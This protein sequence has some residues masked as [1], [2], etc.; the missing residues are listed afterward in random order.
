MDNKESVKKENKMK[1]T[2]FIFIGVLV[3]LPFIH[4]FNG[5]EFTDTAYSLGNYENL[6]NMNMTWTI[7][8]FWANVLGKAFT[9]LPMGNMWIGMKFY[10]TL[11]PVATIIVSYLFLRKYIPKWILFIGEILAVSMFWCPTT[12]LYNYLTYFLF[13]VV[14]VL[15][16]YSLEKQSSLGLLAAGIVLAFSVFTRFP[17]ITEA[18]LIVVVWLDSLI[19]KRKFSKGLANT[20]LC[21]GG[22]LVGVG[23]N[24]GIISL[25]Y[26]FNS[27]PDMIASLFSMTDESTGY[28]PKQM[29]IDILTSYITYTKSYVVLVGIA[30]LVFVLGAIVRKHFMR[31]AFCVAEVILYG[32]FLV[33]AYRS[34]GVF[35]LNYSE[36]ASIYFWMT[37]FLL[38][39]NIFAIWSLLRK[40]TDSVH[41]LLALSTVVIVWITP[42][43]SNNVL[44]PAFNNLCIVA[45][46]TLYM[47][48]NELFRGRNFYELID[49]ESKYSMVATRIIVFLL[50]VS[51]MF[52]SLIFG[53]VFVFRDTGF[54][55]NNHYAIENNEVLKGMH[56]NADNAALISE[57]TV[58]VRENEMENEKAIFYGDLPGLEY[59]LKMPCA[60]SHTWPNLASYTVK[61]FENDINKLDGCP[62][63]FV[64][65][66]FVPDIFDLTEDATEK[67][68][69]LSEYMES[70]G[71]SLAIRIQNIAVYTVDN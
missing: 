39:A 52:Q 45:P 31:V 42:L 26:G 46:V 28:K 15:I 2:D 64:N 25:K 4:L 1:A 9:M 66:K 30:L 60:I 35:N 49:M 33:W 38:L 34:A 16:V 11:V 32:V 37:V 65:E 24:V 18:A 17:N 70:N 29:I 48:W 50:V 69:I 53:F 44:Y 43:G 61:E 7:A 62:V 54:F 63:I 19:N 58:F 51:I 12:I 27:I 23:I 3:L 40:R 47:L 13:T 10:T 5:V 56:T 6:S 59:I 8:T 14:V 67:E 36:Y 68:C 57:L 71:Y 41:K 20:F 22:F 55:Y 21:I